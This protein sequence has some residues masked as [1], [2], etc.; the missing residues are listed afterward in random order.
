M[1]HRQLADSSILLLFDV[2][3]FMFR[4]LVLIRSD[5]GWR[6][7]RHLF[8]VANFHYQLSW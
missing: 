1:Q 7:Q 2:Y 8:K 5:E 3:N 6:S 4:A